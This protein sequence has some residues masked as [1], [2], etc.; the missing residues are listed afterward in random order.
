MW[1]MI[2]LIDQGQWVAVGCAILGAAAGFYYYFRV[3][4]AMYT[5]EESNAAGAI[6]LGL[7]T[8]VV[9]VALAVVVV[10]LGVYPK[11]LQSLLSSSITAAPVLSKLEAP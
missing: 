11:P 7:S 5:P 10:A 4:L 9:A 2:G 3:I 1:V 8:R 6:T